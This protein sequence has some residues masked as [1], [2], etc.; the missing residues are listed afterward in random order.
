MATGL[1][2]PSAITP[3]N[4][5]LAVLKRR[6]LDWTVSTSSDPENDEL[7]RTAINGGINRLNS[8]NW[9]KLIKSVTISLAA[10][11][12][13]YSIPLD[14]RDP[15]HCERQN[16]SAYPDGRFPYKSLKSLLDEH[17]HD[18]DSGDPRYYTIQHTRRV[19]FFDTTPSQTFVTKYPYARLYYHRR[20]PHLT[21]NSSQLEYPNEFE[22]FVVWY[23]REEVAGIK[24][25]D[26]FA[27]AN[28]RRMELWQDL[29]ADDTDTLTDGDT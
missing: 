7:A 8:R 6:V 22:E 27:L 3:H 25:P 29:K 26:K 24:A 4:S 19:L 21:G 23:A 10:D 17:P 15:R 11:T 5:S 14:F 16:S 13:E 20:H 9:Q 12:S 18:T 2:Q 28:R 1:P